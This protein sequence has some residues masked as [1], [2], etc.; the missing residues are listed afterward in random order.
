MCGELLAA[1]EVILALLCNDGLPQVILP[2]RA[3][4]VTMT[5]QSFNLPWRVVRDDG[6]FTV[7]LRK[8]AQ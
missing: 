6:A 4:L 2:A 7:V 1:T 3:P 8:D 5:I